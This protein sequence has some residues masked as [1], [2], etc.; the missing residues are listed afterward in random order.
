M[1]W[2]LIIAYL[3]FCIILIAKFITIFT[4]AFT[5]PP[6]IPSD[7]KSRA[8]IA[9]LIGK[10]SKN[11]KIIYDL[12]SGYGDLAFHISKKH[13]L[14]KIIGIERLGYA[15]FIS[16]VKRKLFGYKNVNL[17]RGDY[18][19]QDYQEA[20]VIVGFFIQSIMDKVEEKLTPLKGKILISNNFYLPNIEPL[21]VIKIRYLL[22]T[23]KI[24]VYR[25]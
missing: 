19:K 18:F 4:W 7:R 20:D 11:P 1:E 21:E 6:S 22:S 3:L 17:I 14:S 2:L 12:G 15:I 24:Y 13:P 23:R 16:R 5:N 8:K 10:Y 25:F 9:E